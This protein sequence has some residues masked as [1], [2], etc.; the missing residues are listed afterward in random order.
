M[1]ETFRTRQ[2]GDN[3]LEDLNIKCKQSL[4]SRSTSLATTFISQ[5]EFKDHGSLLNTFASSM[6]RTVS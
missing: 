5:I 3:Y 2:A 4:V 1:L 6:T